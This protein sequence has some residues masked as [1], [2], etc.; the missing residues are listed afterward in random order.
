MQWTTVEIVLRF[1]VHAKL[2][3]KE[4]EDR[5]GISLRG[6]EIP[7]LLHIWL[8][9]DLSLD[10]FTNL[11]EES[12]KNLFSTLGILIFC[13]CAVFSY[14]LL[15]RASSS[16]CKSDENFICEYGHG[17]CVCHNRNQPSYPPTK[18]DGR[19]DYG[20]CLTPGAATGNSSYCCSGSSE[21]DS[22]NAGVDICQ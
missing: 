14:S 1:Q 15:A 16:D 22:S 6:V 7:Q 20:T 4:L 19:P 18:P 3:P 12:M 2:P 8:L 11:F 17:Y 10:N 9:F 13:V 5:K 21:P